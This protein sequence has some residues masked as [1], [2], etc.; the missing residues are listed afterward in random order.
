MKHTAFLIMTSTLVA[1]AWVTYHAL[2]FSA[3][4]P[5]G[6]LNPNLQFALHADSREAF[7]STLLACGVSA[8]SFAMISW[9]EG[10]LDQLRGVIEGGRTPTVVAQPVEVRLLKE[11]IRSGDLAAVRK[12]AKKSVLDLVDEHYLTPL[13]LADLYE[14]QPIIKALTAAMLKHA[15][16]KRPPGQRIL[17]P[18]SQFALGKK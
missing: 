2:S 8:Y 1:L 12:H 14:Q 10:K 5:P 9:T 3:S 13:E 17:T 7:F 4:T 16:K 15:E 6:L 18:S 11:A